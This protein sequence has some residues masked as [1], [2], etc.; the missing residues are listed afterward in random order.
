MQT[1]HRRT[2]TMNVIAIRRNKTYKYPLRRNT[3]YATCEGGKHLTR[4][5]VFK[6]WVRRRIY[7]PILYDHLLYG[8]KPEY[9]DTCC[10]LCGWDTRDLDS[11]WWVEGSSNHYSNPD[12][13]ESWTTHYLCPKC[14]IQFQ[15][16]DS[17]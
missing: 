14:G 16:F 1:V 2:N 6:M 4:W 10:P 9:E 12:G 15:T 11:H 7:L 17:N 3:K 13:Y 8:G 5:D